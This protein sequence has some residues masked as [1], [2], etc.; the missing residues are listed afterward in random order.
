MTDTGFILRLKKGLGKTRQKIAEG[1]D[2]LKTD[3][4][5]L[6][7]RW[8]E[9][10]EILLTAD[11]GLEITERIHHDLI[12]W[13]KQKKTH[14]ENL[15]DALK[16]S[17]LSL[18][19]GADGRIAESPEPPTV[20]LV[21]GVNGTGKTTTMAKLA[22]SLKEQGKTVLLAAADTF[23][24]AA[25]EQLS[26]LGKTA[27][28]EVISQKM[29][30]DPA[31][32]AFDALARAKATGTDYLFVDTAGRLHTKYNLL[33]ELKKIKR[34]MAKE[35]EGAPHETLLV[36]DATI[37]QNNIAQAKKFKEEIAITGII[38]TKLDGTAKGGAVFPIYDTLKIPV[39]FIGV[40]EEINDLLGF[41]AHEFVT[42]L[43]N[44]N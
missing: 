8:E 1:I 30:A 33:E 43:L 3:G 13:S 5:K 21:V 6:E 12:T 25:I 32:V 37:G 29:G 34:V 44:T 22:A 41:D 4:I 35:L 26:L 7:D 38:L 19:I 15:E 20:V 23:R 2:L 28:V 31:S 16:R 39:K 40:G 14:D 36:L 11:I 10:E 17:L 18:I 24:D 42:S 9:L 27:G